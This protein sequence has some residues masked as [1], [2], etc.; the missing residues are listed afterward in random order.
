MAALNR[1]K[2]IGKASI[3]LLEAAGIANAEDLAAQDID[4]LVA[5]L[6]RANDVLAI[7]KR[8]PGKATVLKWISNARE[9][10]GTTPG[11]EP[12]R[13]GAEPAEHAAAPEINHEATPAVAE[14]LSRSPCAIPL[15]G[16][17]MVGKGLA[18]ADIPAGLLLNR[19]PG[20][21]DVRVD[22]N[23]TRRTVVQ[24]RRTFGKQSTTEDKS[25]RRQFD[26]SMAKP[27]VSSQSNGKRIAKSTVDEDRVSLI[28]APREQT[29]LGKDPES[30]AYI[31]GVLHTHPWS[32]R[33][34]AIFSLL[35]LLDLPLAIIASFLLLLSRK[36]PES[37]P[38][39]PEWFLAFPL[40]LPLIGFGYLAWGMSG[41]C[42]ICTQQ[43][44]IHKGA[45]KH[46]KAHHLPGMGYV[47]PL[48]LHLLL[49]S[50]FRC[51]SCGTPVRL[52]K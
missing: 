17:I 6:Q 8:V 14:M 50:W 10:S 29:N 31:R 18:V 45:L 44:F 15:P 21:L 3:Q 22:E 49:F 35:L 46:I 42:R 11:K 26:L 52:K 30:R 5:E 38:W 12:L 19:Y 16:R 23:T 47:V 33:M 51:S 36:M 27:M 13:D 39:V 25:I 7:S 34:G 24:V 1:I 9:L 28:R 37:F 41:K 32:L 20:A 2:G 4:A 48:S 40:A 43:L